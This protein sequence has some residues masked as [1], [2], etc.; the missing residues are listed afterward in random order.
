MPRK[1][2]PGSAVGSRQGQPSQGARGVTSRLAGPSLCRG[3]WTRELDFASRLPAHVLMA[4]ASLP[5]WEPRRAL[6][7]PGRG[8]SG[9]GCVSG[10]EKE[11]SA[12]ACGPRDPP[13]GA[14]R[15]LPCG[16]F[17]P[18]RHS[19][20]LLVFLELLQRAAGRDCG[21]PMTSQRLKSLPWKWC[22]E[23]YVML[24]VGIGVD[25]PFLSASPE[26]CKSLTQARIKRSDWNQ[27][28]FQSHS[29]SVSSSP[30]LGPSRRHHQNNLPRRLP[31]YHLY[32]S[33]LYCG[34]FSQI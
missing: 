19:L 31:L 5:P 11:A 10:L 21:D 13:M 2:K 27:S 32:P 12:V 6:R 4:E 26:P 33:G 34:Q 25:C 28:G 20:P 24:Y 9:K 8:G 15:F 22:P 18:K 29:P 30:L 17:S 7:A 3:V 23:G 16:T 14:R 1:R